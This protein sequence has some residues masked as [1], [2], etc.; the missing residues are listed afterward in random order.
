[1]NPINIPK[2]NNNR[3]I[4]DISNKSSDYYN[5]VC[6]KTTSKSGTDITLKDR[7]NEFVENNMTLCEEDCNLVDYNYTNQKAK[8]SCL[9]KISIPIINEIKFNKTRLYN[10]FTDVKNI[11]NILF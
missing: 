6:S 8:C 11:A 10:S 5:N 2:M 4:I 9:V 3:L 1:M 7:R